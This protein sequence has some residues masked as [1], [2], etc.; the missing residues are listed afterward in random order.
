MNILVVED[1]P[2][3]QKTIA[4]AL[5]LSGHAVVGAGTGVEALARLDEQR[6]DLVLLDL[7]MPEMDGW[8]FLRHLRADTALANVPVAVMSAAH[9][10]ERQRLDVE[11]IITKPF[12]LDELLDTVDELLA[13]RQQA[14]SGRHPRSRS[15]RDVPD[16]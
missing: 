12:D 1:E 8:E 5:K 14:A 7:Q 6:P 4:A 13:A 11:A 9:R 16:D 3:L 2:A 10:I 15:V